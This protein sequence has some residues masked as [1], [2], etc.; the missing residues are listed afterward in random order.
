MIHQHDLHKICGMVKNNF[1]D[2]TL[3]VPYHY[4]MFGP[5]NLNYTLHKMGSRHPTGITWTCLNGNYRRDLG[6]ISRELLENCSWKGS[7][8]NELW[9]KLS[10]GHVSI[11]WL[12][13]CKRYQAQVGDAGQSGFK[14]IFQNLSKARL[15]TLIMTRNE[16]NRPKCN[17]DLS[18]LK[19]RG[20]RL[21]WG[22]HV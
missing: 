21:F 1:N 4:R 13:K 19:G 18:H 17:E 5:R 2:L 8:Y 10:R 14:V 20:S 12:S 6:I 22:H 11:N 7:I 15:C 3:T 16:S 9:L